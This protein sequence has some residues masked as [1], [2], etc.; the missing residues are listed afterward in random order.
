MVPGQVAGTSKRVYVKSRRMIVVEGRRTERGGTKYG[1]QKTG[2]HYSFSLGFVR[3]AL[4]C[5]GGWVLGLSL[6]S[7]VG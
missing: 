7:A 1:D 2:G 6:L 5:T 3:S 4:H